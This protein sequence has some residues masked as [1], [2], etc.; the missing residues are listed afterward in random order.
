M[1]RR[2]RFDVGN[3][4]SGA[5]IAGCKQVGTHQVVAYVE[6]DGNAAEW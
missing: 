1:K 3:A 5:V 2:C 4:S 6:S